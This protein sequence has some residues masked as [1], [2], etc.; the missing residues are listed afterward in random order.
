M[1]KV[2]TYPQVAPKSDKLQ[3]YLLTG[4]IETFGG[5]TYT[6]FN[7]SDN[8]NFIYFDYNAHTG[9]FE[10]TECSFEVTEELKDLVWERFVNTEYYA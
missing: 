2:Q 9:A 7:Y 3:D 10:I 1:Q 5:D 6:L 8:V 4:V